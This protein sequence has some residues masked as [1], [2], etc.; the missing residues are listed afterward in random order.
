M[1]F[2]NVAGTPVTFQVEVES[3]KVPGVLTAPKEW[4]FAATPDTKVWE[5]PPVIP[6]PVTPDEIA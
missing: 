1:V 5:R 2:E 4:I 3:L 6:V